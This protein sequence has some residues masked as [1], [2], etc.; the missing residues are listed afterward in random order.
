[1]KISL[2]SMLLASALADV[3]MAQS[4][5]HND[6]APESDTPLHQFH[7]RIGAYQGLAILRIGGASAEPFRASGGL[8]HFAALRPAPASAFAISGPE[9]I[10]L[11]SVERNGVRPESWSL[12]ASLRPHAALALMAAYAH[13]EPAHAIARDGSTTAWVLGAHYTL[14]SGS[15]LLAYG[16]QQ[17]AMLP[18]SELLSIGYEYALS[19]RHA[20]YADATRRENA[21]AHKHLSIGM[22]AAF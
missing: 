19:T 13:H 20:I 4:I 2:L 3:A 16:R 8:P 10:G 15:L 6:A 18:R 17:P 7:S 22:R 9:Q 21:H 1:M 5:V 11:G 12:A 14:A